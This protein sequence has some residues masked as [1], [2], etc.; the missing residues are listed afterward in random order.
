MAVAGIRGGGNFLRD[1]VYGLNTAEGRGRG[2]AFFSWM[3][4]SGFD[5]AAIG[6][7]FDAAQVS[8]VVA[9][10]HRYLSVGQT[11]EAYGVYLAV[12]QMGLHQPGPG[13]PAA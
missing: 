4:F 12:E 6:I 1:V 13:P 2:A 8:V 9:K 7:Y 3:P 10:F 5:G 11:P